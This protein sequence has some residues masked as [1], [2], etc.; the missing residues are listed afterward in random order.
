MAPA[1]DHDSEPVSLESEFY[2]VYNLLSM[3]SP[4]RLKQL[5]ELETK[6]GILFQN[7]EILNQALTHS[8][9]AYEEKLEHAD[10]E[11]MEFLG[12]A[13][14]KLVM[15]ERLYNQFPDKPEGDLT[16]IRATVVSDHTFANIARNA[17]IGDY[18]L[19]GSNEKRT[20]GRKR[21]SSIANAFE[22]L[23]GAIYLDSGLGKAAEFL[24]RMLDPQVTKVSQEGYVS[25]YKSSLQE[26][27]Q[28]NKWGL[29]QYK[30]VKETGLKHKRVFWVQ[31][32]I[33]TKV[34]GMGRGGS[35]KEAEQR[36]ATQAFRKLQREDEEKAAKKETQ[37]LGDKNANGVQGV[38]RQFRRRIGI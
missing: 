1:K 3:L 6:L 9:Y 4:E 35:K 18:L 33:K 21:K 14:I 20:G 5:E 25:D 23:I 19:L 10:N 17:E 31:V 27:V 36:A 15:S 38:I 24:V 37:A 32:K 2:I 13:V 30:L 22:A 11:R 34:Y 7:K 12:D 8:S 28:K 26:I 29:P 16:K